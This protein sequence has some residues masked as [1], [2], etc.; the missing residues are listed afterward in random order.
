MR[1][2]PMLLTE[3]AAPYLEKTKGSVIVISGGLSTRTHPHFMVYSMSC[4]A[5][6]HFVRNAANLYTP[7]GIRINCVK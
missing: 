6:D 5:R 1:C 2:R 3:K 7:R 4:A